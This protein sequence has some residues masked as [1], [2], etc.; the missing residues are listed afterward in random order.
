MGVEER[1]DERNKRRRERRPIGLLGGE[2]DDVGKKEAALVRLAA[3]STATSGIE[4]AAK[5][6]DNV[7][8]HLV[9]RP[10]MQS[11]CGRWFP[12][13]EFLFISAPRPSLEAPLHALSLELRHARLG[14]IALLPRNCNSGRVSA[15][16]PR[17]GGSLHSLSETRGLGLDGFAVARQPIDKKAPIRARHDARRGNC[18]ISSFAASL[19]KSTMARPQFAATPSGRRYSDRTL[20]FREK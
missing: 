5:R 6:I 12:S 3:A 15:V 19:K 18:R 20:E 9:T 13:M 4:G 10:K 16:A 2:R 7:S 17:V 11:T 14:G 8:S 1:N